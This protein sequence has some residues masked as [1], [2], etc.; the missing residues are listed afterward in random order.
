MKDSGRTSNP[1][2]SAATADSP[3][4]RRFALGGP[5][6]PLD[7]ARHAFRADVADIALAGQVIASHYAEPLIRRCTAET[8]LLDSPSAPSNETLRVGDAFAVLD[9][10][11]GLAWGYRVAD[12]VVGYVDESRLG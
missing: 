5:T 12:H 11:R 10:G 1:T 3:L 8:P 7:P 2:G 6:V 4:P 9:C